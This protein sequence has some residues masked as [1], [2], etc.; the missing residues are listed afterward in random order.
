MAVDLQATAGRIGH[1]SACG[2]C[3][4]AGGFV[5]ERDTAHVDALLLDISVEDVAAAFRDV[6]MD[7]PKIIFECPQCGGGG[8]A[9]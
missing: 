3:K 1:N 5:L 7:Q 2:K 4:G 9:I 6:P 8:E